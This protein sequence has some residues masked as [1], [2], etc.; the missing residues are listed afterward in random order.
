MTK[1]DLLERI[2]DRAAQAEHRLY[3]GEDITPIDREKAEQAIERALRAME[4]YAPR[5]VVA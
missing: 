1:E 2:I 3:S 5:L 4:C